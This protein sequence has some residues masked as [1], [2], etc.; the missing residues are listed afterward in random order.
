MIFRNLQDVTIRKYGT[1]FLEAFGMLPLTYFGAIGD[2]VTDNY[3]NLQVAIDESI[4]RGLRYIFVPNGNYY[5]YGVLENVEKVIFI[6]NTTYA[7]IFNQKNEKIT[8]YQIGTQ[9]PFEKGT[10]TLDDEVTED[11]YIDIPTNTKNGTEAILVIDSNVIFVTDNLNVVNGKKYAPNYDAGSSS[12]TDGFVFLR[13]ESTTDFIY[14]ERV[15]ILETAI[16][17]IYKVVG[18]GGTLNKTVE[19]RER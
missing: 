17:L 18:S 19:W 15:E 5:Y 10:K 4:K 2:N 12:S 8:I 14:V 13:Y 6:G 9:L 3:A 1:S 11:G 7:K 16:R